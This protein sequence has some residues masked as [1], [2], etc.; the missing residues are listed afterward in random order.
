MDERLQQIID[1]IVKDNVLVIVE[2]IKDR[3]ALFEFEIKNVMILNKP[4]YKI[5]EEVVHS[6]VKKCLVLTDLDKKGRELYARISKDLRKFGVKVDDKL[7]NYL[8][9]ETKL[10]QI[11]GLRTYLNKNFT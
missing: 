8:F 1:D 11:E 3:K 9:K 4:L 2:G 6:R 5:V 10:R 7:R